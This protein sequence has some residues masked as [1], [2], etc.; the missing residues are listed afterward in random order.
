MSPAGRAGPVTAG[1]IFA[2]D[3]YEK[4]QHG[5]RNEI[6]PNI[7]ATSSGAKCEKA[8]KHGETQKSETFRAYHSF[9]NSY[10]CITAV[11]WMLM[12]WKIQR[13]MQDDA[14]WA[15]R[16]HPGS[17]AELHIW[18][19]FSACLPRSR[20]EKRRSRKPSQPAL[21]Y[22]VKGFRGKASPWK[23]GKRGQPGP[24]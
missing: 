6:R 22:E 21:S 15:A 19:N 12:M 23:T 4:F 2:S 18:Q 3:L 17:R 9:G 5:F 20:L 13:A 1:R 11:K 24:M 8:S 16:V 10:G 7:L 14:I